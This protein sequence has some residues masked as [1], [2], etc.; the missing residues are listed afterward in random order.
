MAWRRFQV[1]G[2]VAAEVTLDHPLVIG[3]DVEDLVQ[4]LLGEVRGAHVGIEAGGRDDE[5]GPG[6]TNTVDIPEGISDFLFGGEFNAE[7]TEA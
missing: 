5:V 7:E 1:A 3:D 4:L 6:R 2:D